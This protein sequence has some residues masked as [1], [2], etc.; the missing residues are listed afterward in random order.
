MKNHYK[1]IAVD[2]LLLSCHVR[3]LKWIYTLLVCECQGTPRSKQARYP[4]LKWGQRDSNP[5]PLS[6]WM[7]TQS[8]S[9]NGSCKLG[10]FG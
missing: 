5:Q 2:C 3:V 4:K 7:N 10:Q 8:L 1:L 9:Q 6:S